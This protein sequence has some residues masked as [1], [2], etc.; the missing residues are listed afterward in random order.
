MEGQEQV[1]FSVMAALRERSR[2][3][4]VLT[5]THSKSHRVQK[6]KDPIPSLLLPNPALFLY[7]PPQKATIFNWW[8][9]L[10]I[11]ERFTNSAKNLG[12]KKILLTSNYTSVLTK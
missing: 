9:I 8:K 2:H 11:V 7:Q 4:S 12:S 3:H 1:P 6:S 10:N 5:E